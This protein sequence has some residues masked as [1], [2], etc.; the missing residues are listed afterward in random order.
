[1]FLKST[2][3]SR[4]PYC[5]WQCALGLDL[6]VMLCS[7][8]IELGVNVSSAGNVNFYLLVKIVCA[9]FSSLKLI[10]I[11]YLGIYKWHKLL[12]WKYFE[13]ILNTLFLIKLYSSAFSYTDYFY[14][15]HSF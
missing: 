8:G 12:V 10:N 14:S 7:Q 4:C 11:L 13:I 2:C 9:D 15:H 3:F 6:R 5:S 1:M